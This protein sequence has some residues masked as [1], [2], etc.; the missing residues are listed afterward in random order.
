MLQRLSNK[1]GVLSEFFILQEAAEKAKK[2]GKILKSGQ[3]PVA[4]FWKMQG[5]R[6]SFSEGW[7]CM[8]G[9]IVH[10]CSHSG[11]SAA[12]MDSAEIC[13]AVTSI[14]SQQLHH[15]LTNSKA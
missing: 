7:S 8:A 4:I 3:P 10:I 15:K 5:S 13:H 6:K 12:C 9:C 1:H 14:L 11:K 2:K